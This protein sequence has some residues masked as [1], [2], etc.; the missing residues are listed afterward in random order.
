AGAGLGAAAHREVTRAA[1]TRGR[2]ALHA[3]LGAL[4]L[5]LTMAAANYVCAE[6]GDDEAAGAAIAVHGVRARPCADLGLPGW[7]R[8]AV[9]HPDDL[10]RTVA[11][12]SAAL[13]GARTQV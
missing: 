13:P 7:V 8:V 5:R 4:G 2:L 9:P 12:L 11:A 10:D 6:V 3:A 1:S